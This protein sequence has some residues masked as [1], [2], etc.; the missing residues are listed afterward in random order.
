MKFSRRKQIS[1]LCFGTRYDWP[2]SQTRF[3]LKSH[4]F[5]DP[6]R[7]E[8]RRAIRLGQYLVSELPRIHSIF[9]RGSAIE[10]SEPS[11][12]R[13]LDL[14]IVLRSSGDV[15]RL[16]RCAEG[17]PEF[18]SSRG[19]SVDLVAVNLNDLLPLR[20]PVSMLT[21]I[22]AFRSLRLW[23]DRIWKTGP[24]IPADDQQALALWREALGDQD[25]ALKSI[26]VRDDFG[27][28]ATA[29]WM[30]KKCLRLGGICSLIA[31][32]RFSRHPLRCAELL[33]KI[34]P[35][36]DLLPQ[37]VW[38]Q[39]VQHD[40]SHTALASLMKLYEGIKKWGN[41]RKLLN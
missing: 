4:F 40:T 39:F 27:D 37:K 11:L 17:F 32:G 10:D 26:D 1:R 13:D 15:E 25:E 34:V 29:S 9:L 7:A 35:G 12:M 16:S 21:L 8:H 24:A 33:Q 5:V 28:A 38:Q 30:Q 20:L 23:G 2:I 22:L 6:E 18:R 14:V 3:F 36:I 19:M 41:V 31:G